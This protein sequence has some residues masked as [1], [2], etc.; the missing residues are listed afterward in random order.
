MELDDF[1]N[2]WDE[3]SNQVNE[4]LNFKIFNKMSKRKF[5]SNLQKI[6]IPEL[7]ASIICVG[8]AI[9]IGFKFN[10]LDTAIFRIAGVSA[11]LLLLIL[12]AISLFSIQQLY[13]STDIGKPY[14]DTLKE[15]AVQKMRFCKLQKLNI[16][17]SYLLLAVVMILVTKFYGNHTDDE[18]A[19]IM[20]FGFSFGYVILL[21]FSKWVFKKYNRIIEQ[22]ENLLKEISA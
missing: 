10:L 16:S 17:L 19:Y 1:K 9:Y 12:P 20:I 4:N 6:A 11:I 21:F 5:N 2:T 13:K 7:L 8:A 18:N 22:T 3:M 14:V 15:F